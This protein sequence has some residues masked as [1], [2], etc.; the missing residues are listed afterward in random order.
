MNV[1]CKE[2]VHQSYWDYLPTEIRDYILDLSRLPPCRNVVIE[3]LKARFSLE[4]LFESLTGEKGHVHYKH[5]TDLRRCTSLG[6][7][8]SSPFK[9][10][11][12]A[13]ACKASHTMILIRVEA[14]SNCRVSFLLGADYSRAREYLL[15]SIVK[16][17][18]CHLRMHEPKGDREGICAWVMG[19]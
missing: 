19:N 9:I 18:E 12:K 5:R 14:R 15:I 6:V 17:M 16:A 2:E 13:A 10:K 11:C 4:A 8:K 3:E 1:A 7:V